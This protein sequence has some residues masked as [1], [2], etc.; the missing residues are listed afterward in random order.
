MYL[1]G[2]VF[3][4]SVAVVAAIVVFV[5]AVVVV[6]I[7]VVVLAVVVVTVVVVSA[8]ESFVVVTLSTKFRTVKVMIVKSVYV[9]MTCHN[10][11]IR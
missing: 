5:V 9:D 6:A 10:R 8:F 2:V 1:P 4:P 7:V 11:N 3:I